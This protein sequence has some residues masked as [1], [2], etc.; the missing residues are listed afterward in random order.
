MEVMT[1][2]SDFDIK[3][4]LTLEKI[5]NLQK[6]TKEIEAGP[7][8]KSYIVNIV[9]A[10]RNPKKYNIKLGKYIDYGGSPR[11]SISLQIAAKADAVLNGQKIV[12]PQNIKNVA[13]DVLR[14]RLILNYEGQAENIESDAIIEEILSKV[15]VP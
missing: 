5:I 15:K 12:T 13:H 14:H 9:N 3:K 11:A 2:E 7:Q 10:T 6:K 4:V 1:G 8:I